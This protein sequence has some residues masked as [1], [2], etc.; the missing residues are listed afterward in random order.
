MNTAR[1]RFRAP[2][3]L[4]FSP[5]PWTATWYLFCSM[6]LGTVAFA[7]ALTVLLTGA[8]LGWLWLGIPLLAAG[9]VVTRGLASVERHRIKPP[10]PAPYRPVGTRGLRARLGQRLRDPATRRDVVLLVVLWVPLFVLDMVALTL[11]L[12]S[13][14]L[15]SLPIWY[16]YIP[17]T[18]DNGT[19]AHGVAFGSFP[20]GPHGTGARGVFVGDL[21]TAL[22]AAA[23]GLVLLLAAA[24]YVVV[25]AA[26]T[27]VAITRALLRPTTNSH[28]AAGQTVTA[29]TGA[30]VAR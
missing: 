23:V 6:L 1:L 28:A 8:V 2:P 15:I 4:L 26:R 14:A 3:V 21:S 11:W 25:A 27:H 22:L 10:I 12:V 5:A 13:F 7:L 18:F 29:D 30:G 19:T 9:L 24:N 16:R 17:T 20:N